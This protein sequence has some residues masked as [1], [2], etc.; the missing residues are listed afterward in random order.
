MLLAVK[1]R[2]QVIAGVAA[3]FRVPRL[4]GKLDPDLSEFPG[5]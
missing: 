5:K 1:R 3:S 2:H 4:A